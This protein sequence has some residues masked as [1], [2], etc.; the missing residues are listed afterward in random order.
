[1]PTCGVFVNSNS[2]AF[3]ATQEVDYGTIVAP[4][5]GDAMRV[6][7]GQ[8][9]SAERQRTVR[10]DKNPS[11]SQTAGNLGRRNSSWSVGMSMAASG[12]AGVVPD[13]DLLLKAAFGKAVAITASTKCTYALDDNTYSLSLF[14][15]FLPDAAAYYR[16]AFGS[17]VNEM[18]AEFGGDYGLLNFSGPSFWVTDPGQLADGATPAD[19]KGGLSSFPTRPSSPTYSGEGATG[20]EGSI[21]IDSVTYGDIVGGRIVLTNNVSLPNTFN[22][23]FPG[24]PQR[25]TRTVTIQNLQMLLTQSSDLTALLGKCAAGTL[26]PVVITVGSGTGKRWKF[27]MA[28]VGMP[29]PRTDDSG[30]RVILDFSGA[31][32]Y[33]TSGTSKD[34]LVLEIL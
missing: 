22:N 15:Y 9:F 17:V 33:P 11:L 19:A 6:T 18:T 14:S 5:N 34:E 29:V 28:N 23:S 4:V 21:V 25:G 26:V 12:S 1:M 27:T 13:C 31:T 2:E 8:R 20:Y 30:E 24:C 7:S 10:P 3:F 32:A 16:C